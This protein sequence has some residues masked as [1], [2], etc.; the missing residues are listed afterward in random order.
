MILEMIFMKLAA[1]KCVPCVGGIPPFKL[2]QI[3]GFLKELH[4]DWKVT[5]NQQIQ[6]AFKFKNFREAMEFINRVAE[7]AETEGHHPDIHLHGWNKVTLTLSTHAIGGLSE[8]DF[9]CA[10]KIDRL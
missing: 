1:Q 8:K 4:A 7:L 2:E 10:A 6:R 5:D 9:I 3:R